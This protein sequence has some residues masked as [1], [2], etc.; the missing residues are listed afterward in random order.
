M[1]AQVASP[2]AITGSTDRRGNPLPRLSVRGFGHINRFWDRSRGTVHVKLLPG[3]YYV[4]RSDELIS[5]VLGSCVAACIWDPVARIGG[6]NHFMIPSG[7]RLKTGAGAIDESARYG[8][9]AMEF[10]INKILRHGGERPRLETKI[11]GGGHVMPIATD[12]GQRNIDFVRHY[13]ATEGLRITSEHVGGP[14]PM[15]LVFHPLDGRARVLEIRNVK[16]DTVVRR[17]RSYAAHLDHAND[18]IATTGGVEL[19]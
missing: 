10:L 17:E 19:F 12:I 15:K 1:A 2:S 7:G 5:T 9:F 11:A 6:M 16:N 3:E 13:L 18:V 4:T 14:Y 8:M